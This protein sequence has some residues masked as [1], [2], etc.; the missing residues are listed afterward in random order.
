MKHNQLPIGGNC[1]HP[2]KF[3]HSKL[4]RASGFGIALLFSLV[5]TSLYA[6]NVE[7]I[8]EREIARRQAALPRGEEALARGRVAMKD[9]NFTVAHE[10]FRVAVSF[11]PDASVSGKSR[12][13]AVEGFCKSGVVLAKQKIADGKYAEAE[14]IAL[15]VLDERYDPNC[16]EAKE[17]VA[18]LRH[19]GYYNRTIG[20]KFIAKVEE[21]KK[22]LV[23]ADGYYNSGRYDLAF[24]K[25][26][27]VLALDPYNTAA[28]RGQEKIDN[29]K[30]RYGEEA[31]NEARARSM[32]Q[33]EKGWEQPVRS[34]GPGVGPL[35]DA[36]AKDVT[37]TAKIS[38]K[39]S[40]IIIPRI[41]FR[42]AS[43]REAIDFIRQQA[44]AND[45]TTEGRKGVD[46]VL[47][48]TP[49]GQMAP[50]SV[51]VQPAAPPPA[52]TVP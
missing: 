33:V 40:T 34:Y 41:E 50:P 14:A 25:Y 13:E 42:D 22:L 46:I 43:I 45:P 44:A 4:F 11:L 27:Q 19:P 32:W 26:D 17:L 24:K 1:F 21:V 29:T 35:A 48:L 39:L 31:Y 10:E 9:Q 16:S 49:L 2:F 37:G 36:F 8:S 23:E 3:G 12:G 47:R 30:Y 28:R 20:P 6:Q 15:E 18:N 52:I 51:P 7:R 38:N 5:C